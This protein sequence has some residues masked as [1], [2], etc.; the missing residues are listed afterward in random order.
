MEVQQWKN[1]CKKLET[2]IVE[3]DKLL[4]NL[5]AVITSGSL[6]IDAQKK[7]YVNTSQNEREIKVEYMEAD[8]PLESTK[9][10]SI[11]MDI[12]I[13]TKNANAFKDEFTN[14]DMLKRKYRINWIEHKMPLDLNFKHKFFLF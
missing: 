1:E 9:E 7:T 5:Q 3:K 11:D 13:M 12:Q 2:I 6:P 10:S 8:D 14:N 4:E